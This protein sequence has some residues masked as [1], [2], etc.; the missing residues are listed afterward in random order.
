MNKV[1]FRLFISIIVL[2]VAVVLPLSLEAV[3]ILYLPK[4]F[5]DREWNEVRSDYE[6]TGLHTTKPTIRSTPANGLKMVGERIVDSAGNIVTEEWTPY[7]PEDYHYITIGLIA[8]GYG[9][10]SFVLKGQT[11]DHVIGNWQSEPIEK[12]EREV[13]QFRIKELNNVINKGIPENRVGHI[14]DIDKV[15]VSATA[16]VFVRS[17]RVTTYGS[18]QEAKT[19]QASLPAGVSA[20]VVIGTSSYWKW[21][22]GMTVPVKVDPKNDL[23]VYEG[24]YFIDINDSVIDVT[25]NRTTL[26]RYYNTLKVTVTNSDLYYVNMAIKGENNSIE[27]IGNYASGNTSLTLQKSF[28]SDDVGYYELVITVSYGPGGQQ[29]AKFTKYVLV[30][31]D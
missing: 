27:N 8:T 30:T 7:K 31:D 19:A 29:T 22:A 15:D 9:E 17:R 12:A 6:S 18:R 14:R 10:V 2:F 24:S 28:S 13:Y 1:K 16:Q 21:E 23:F 26:T 11:R 25:L 4:E 3:M 20:G 5:L